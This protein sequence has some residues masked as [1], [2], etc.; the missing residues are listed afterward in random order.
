MISG[1]GHAVLLREERKVIEEGGGS[2]VCFRTEVLKS[3]KMD[4]MLTRRRST[5]FL[6]K[7]L[8]AT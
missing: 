3:K 4:D 5:D 2:L 8:S 7:L 1:E 6:D